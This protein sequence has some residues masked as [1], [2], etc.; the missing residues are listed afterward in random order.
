MQSFVPHKLR[1]LKVILF[2]F[3][4]SIN[5]KIMEE[6]EMAHAIPLHFKCIERGSVHHKMTR[7]FVRPE[8]TITAIEQPASLPK[9]IQAYVINKCAKK[10]VLDMEITAQS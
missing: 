8:S 4:I 3:P 10:L 2:Q 7:L 9:N 6:W 5:V 1:S